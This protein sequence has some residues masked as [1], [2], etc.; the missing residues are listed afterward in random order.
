MKAWVLRRQ[1][2]VWV[3]G[4]LTWNDITGVHGIF[5]LDET[6]AVHQ[7]DF[8]DVASAMGREVGLNIGLGR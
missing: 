7:L 1:E 6:E 3:G 5:V 2:R 4:Q 8:G